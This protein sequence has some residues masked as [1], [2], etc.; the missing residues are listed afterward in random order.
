[1][2]LV[3]ATAAQAESDVETMQD[4]TVTATRVDRSIYEV[5]AAV[6]VV[7]STDITYGE[8]RLGLD[9]TLVRLPGLF[10]QTA[11]TSHRVLKYPFV[12]LDQG[13]T[14]AHAA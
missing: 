1:M 11:T 6:G 12:V 8:Q 10:L 2:G 4:I 5:P 7:D 13:Q 3:V 14:L 9:E